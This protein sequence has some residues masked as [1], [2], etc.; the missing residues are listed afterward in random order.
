[1]NGGKF[2]GDYVADMALIFEASSVTGLHVMM[3]GK[4]GNGKTDI[5]EAA[6]ESI[7]NADEWLFIE[8]DP[9]TPPEIVNGYPDPSVFYATGKYAIDIENTL[10]DPNKRCIILNEFSRAM[11]AVRYACIKGLTRQTKEA[12]EIMRLHGDASL[13]VVW[14]TNNFWPKT[15]GNEAVLS[16]FP[17]IMWIPDTDFDHH[18]IIR[19]S[20]KSMGGIM[21]LDYT[22]PTSEQIQKVRGWR[23]G[24]EAT[25]AVDDVAG[26]L[27][28][29][30]TDYNQRDN[31]FKFYIRPRN[32]KQWST[33]LYRMSALRYDDPN[34]AQVHDDAIRLLQYA[35]P[36]HD[37]SEA[38]AWQSITNKICDP[39]QGAINNI[40]ATAHEKMRGYNGDPSEKAIILGNY[41]TVAKGNLKDLATRRNMIDPSTGE[42]TDPRIRKC[43]SDLLMAMAEIVRG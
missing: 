2:V 5:S 38:A 25:Q 17:L 26:V 19:Q 12:R 21:S 9:S 4:S 36:T 43:E 7:Y 40:F 16:R 8:L 34:P 14:A 22:F 6:A 20:M 33:L 29:E 41:Y 31:P 11:D 37:E 3:N 35:W 32:D 39:L 1:M 13:P 28:D 42:Y 27:I 18:A 10:L 23:G 24:D 30:I 15:E